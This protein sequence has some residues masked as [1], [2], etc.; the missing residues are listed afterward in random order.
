MAYTERKLKTIS[1]RA[2]T[3]YA[4]QHNMVE[5]HTDQEITYALPLSYY[6]KLENG[7]VCMVETRHGFVSGWRVDGEWIS[8]YT[9]EELDTQAE[10]KRAEIEKALAEQL[11][12]NK[13]ELQP[14]Q[15]RLPTF[16]RERL[17]FFHEV[18]GDRF[19][20]QGWKHEIEVAELTLLYMKSKGE[21]S[22]A[23][24]AYADKHTTRMNQ[25][26]IAKS[27]AAFAKQHPGRTLAG[28]M[29]AQFPLTGEL[30]Y[31][32]QPS[33]DDGYEIARIEVETQ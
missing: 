9:D 10:I 20:Y 27:L 4:D 22:D 2:I 31:G 29:S 13:R 33:E 17:E 25:H 14:R 3:K 16:L 19:N 26:E 18:A 21:D 30:A 32:W 11:E 23:V 8:R 1:I 6:E 5:V 7:Q 28:S 12:A 24:F 15:D